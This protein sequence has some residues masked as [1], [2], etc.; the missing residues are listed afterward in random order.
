VAGARGGDGLP[1]CVARAIAGTSGPV[2]V[3]F[4]GGLDSTVLLHA[5]V[6]T[7]AASTDR[8]RLRA[9][10][11]NH[12]LHA[13]ADAW[14]R[15]CAG[16]ATSL[17]I[18]FVARRV[19]VAPQGSVEA[20]ARAA[21]YAAF[22]ACLDSPDS[23]LLLAHHRDDQA[24]TVLLRL[25]QGR[26]LYG[27]PAARRLGAGRVVRPLL[28]EPRSRLLEYAR[29]AELT[30]IEDPANADPALD[31]NFVRHRILPE[32]RTRFPKVDAALVRA[33]AARESD[34]QQLPAALGLDLA[35][36]ALPLERLLASGPQEQRTV[37]R[38]WLAVH[39][40]AIPAARALDEF[41]AQLR[42]APDRHPCLELDRGALRRHRGQVWLCAPAPELEPSYSITAPGDLVLPHGRLV[43]V[44]A[45]SGFVCRGAVTVRFRAGGE[46]IRTSIGTRP[47]KALL[48]DAC[49]APWLRASWPLVWDEDGLAAVSGL[50]ERAAGLGP[51]D[52][53]H[54]GP[55]FHAR[56]VPD[57][58]APYPDL[59]ASM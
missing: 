39:G 20:R 33:I 13:D 43:M 2:Y 32:L 28:G 53:C 27:M 30:W 29:A 4:S 45:V 51:G 8:A 57:D 42:A 49:V 24:E 17:G 7:I 34:E 21:R 47:V 37:L 40:R 48:Q 55:R 54:D 12:S 26:G 23:V 9:L 10:H 11:V 38:L 56:W 19:S 41:A 1:G 15:H 14:E 16:V 5:A 59:V 46:C 36:P 3:G 6:T 35:A 58:L 50:A 44:S 25:L 52:R 22:A 18:E 31:R